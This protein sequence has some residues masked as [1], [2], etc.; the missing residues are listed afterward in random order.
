MAALRDEQDRGESRGRVFQPAKTAEPL[1]DGRQWVQEAVM[2]AEIM[3]SRSPGLRHRCASR[4]RM[5]GA[6]LADV[7]DVENVADLVGHK[8]LTLA[9][10]P[11]HL[12]LIKRRAVVS[13]LGASD[14]ASDP[15]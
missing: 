10:R 1:E 12:G 5:E 3:D 15:N 14:T 11:A 8:S 13:L 9:R 6:P 4:L 2:Q 7:A